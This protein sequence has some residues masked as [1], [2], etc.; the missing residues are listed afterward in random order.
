MRSR[1]SAAASNRGHFLHFGIALPKLINTLGK[2][3]ATQLRARVAAVLAGVIF[4]VSLGTYY[5]LD[6][7]GIGTRSADATRDIRLRAALAETLVK[8]AMLAPGL[9]MTSQ[10]APLEVDRLEAS[11]WL[12]F[13][14]HET[15]SGVEIAPAGSPSIL[16]NRKMPDRQSNTL[17]NNLATRQPMT[18]AAPRS[19]SFATRGHPIITI[20]DRSMVAKQRIQLRQGRNKPEFWGYVTSTMK[21]ADLARVLRFDELEAQG[22]AVSLDY[23]R[24]DAVRSESILSAGGDLRDDSIIHEIR[25][26]QGDKMYLRASP[27]ASWAAFPIR[28]AELL[29]LLGAGGC[30]SLVVYWLLRPPVGLRQTVALPTSPLELDKPA[31]ADAGSR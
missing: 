28:L 20:D 1:D 18:T 29:A 11:A 30:I 12:I 4:A 13:Q 6:R 9:L 31:Y 22:Y 16:F 25:L 21:L 24:S 15:I 19:S 5:A 8:Q 10:A 2:L 14:I 7:H 26:P 3:R 27:P 23:F 17:P